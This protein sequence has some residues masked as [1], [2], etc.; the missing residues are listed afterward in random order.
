MTGATLEWDL[1]RVTMAA[2][3]LDIRG[4]R[5]LRVEWTRN[6]RRPVLR[7]EPGVAPEPLEGVRTSECDE[8]GVVRHWFETQVS[9]CRVLWEAA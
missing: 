1:R 3:E 6:H 5:T 9:G 4:W 2:N 7:V 8:H